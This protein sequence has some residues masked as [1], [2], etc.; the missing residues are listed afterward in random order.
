MGRK[1]SG[2]KR[3]AITPKM[4]IWL[5]DLLPLIQAVNLKDMSMDEL[6]ELGGKSKSTLYEYFESKEE[7]LA[8]AIKGLLV[9]LANYE[10][11][12]SEEADLIVEDYQKMIEWIATNVQD[13]SFGFLTQ[14]K[15]DFPAIWHHV[16]Q[17]LQVVLSDIRGLYERGIEAKVFSQVSVDL[18]IGLD[19]FFVMEWIT[20]QEKKG[21]DSERLDQ[22]IR[23]YVD[24]RMKGILRR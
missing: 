10:I 11:T 2:R 24:I 19:E 22:L 5:K 8:I 23:D 15:R 6:A 1:S 7:I 9:N 17:F 13:I 16:D 18:L 20:Q 3:K 14:M 4:L 21:E 12:R